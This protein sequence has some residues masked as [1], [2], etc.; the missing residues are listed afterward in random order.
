M[1]AQLLAVPE[2]C[3]G[4][5][6]CATVCSALKE[7]LFRP[8]RARLHVTNFPLEGFSAPS[9]CFHCPKANCRKACPEK[10][11]SRDEH[12]AVVVDR[13]LCNG[14]GDCVAACPYG[15]IVLDDE[16]KAFKCDLCG[17]DPAC[18][19]ECEF[20]ALLYEKPEGDLLKARGLQMK[21]RMPREMS[22]EEKRRN[23]AANLLKALRDNA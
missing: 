17:G 21:Q 8:S 7:G 3:T 9:I 22:P 12:G 1:T 5:V 20:G 14:C 18:V 10:A 6:R 15:M 16:A 23:L 11:I 13:S 2:R 4:C 19:K